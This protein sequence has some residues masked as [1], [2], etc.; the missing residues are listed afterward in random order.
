MK[1]SSL[2]D[3]LYSEAVVNEIARLTEEATRM[4]SDA[5]LLVQASPA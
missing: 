3:V 5:E 4:A 1:L 2:T